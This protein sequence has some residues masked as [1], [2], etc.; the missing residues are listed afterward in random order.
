[1][2]E[3]EALFED[4]E[5][6]RTGNAR[7][8]SLHEI[9]VIAVC[10]VLCGGQTCADMA[11]FGRSKRKFLEEFLPLEN[12]IPSHDTFSRVFRLLDA[13]RFHGWFL[14]FMQ[15]FAE[16]C[17]GVVAI[18]G[19][20]MRRSFD[21]ASGASPLH[22]VS[23]WAA[24]QRLVLGQVAVDAKSNEIVAV[25]KLLELLSLAGRVVTADAMNCQHKIAQQ[26]IDQQGDYVLALKGNQGSLHDDV[27]C[28]LD[29]R[30]TPLASASDIDKGHG[31]IETRTASVSS[32]IDWL[33]ERHGWPGLMAIGKVTASREIGGKTTQETRYYL[34]SQAFTPERFNEIVR[35]HWS[36]ENQLHWVLDVIMDE[37]Q[38]RNRKD[39]GPEN[40]ALLRKLAL[41]LAKL[42]P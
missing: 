22:L 35:T 14:S 32:D 21:R 33:R 11:L 34:L 20:T 8:H 26:V 15:R 41:N 42:E 6:P 7:L 37:D 25:P 17:E 30:E 28:F 1:M 10:T 23:A 31:R 3:L 2:D 4:L 5:D 12:G 27:R 36:I 29:D 38:A 9:L 40:L 13:E 39:H 19:K 16:G 18:D 24:D